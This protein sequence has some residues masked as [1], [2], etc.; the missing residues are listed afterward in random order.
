MYED[1]KKS[2]FFEYQKYCRMIL[3]RIKKGRKR[4]EETSPPEN[5]V[6]ILTVQ[7]SSSLIGNGPSLILKGGKKEE[8][9]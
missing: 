9:K 5:K 7:R 4:E 6:R 1:I 2:L 8:H 3:G